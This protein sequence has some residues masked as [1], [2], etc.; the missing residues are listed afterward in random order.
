M[1][2]R[3]ASRANAAATPTMF[4][5]VGREIWAGGDRGGRC[6][7]IARRPS[8]IAR[9]QGCAAAAAHL[10]P[11]RRSGEP[12]RQHRGRATWR[13]R[14]S[15]SDKKASILRVEDGTQGRHRPGTPGD[16]AIDASRQSATAASVTIAGT[17][18]FRTRIGDSARLHC[19]RG[20]PGRASP[21]WPGQDPSAGTGEARR[22]QR[23]HDHR[24]RCQTSPSRWR[25]VDSPGRAAGAAS[26][27]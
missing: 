5:G 14:H 16:P 15:G 7:A 12:D 26:T 22:Q 8:A 25:S 1:P 13:H 21:R 19:R 18:A 11:G 6:P 23:V 2:K 3:C 20:W 27:R 9:R 17:D 10:R 24:R 4:A